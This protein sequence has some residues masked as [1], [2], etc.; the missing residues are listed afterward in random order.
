MHGVCVGLRFSDIVWWAWRSLRVNRV[1]TVLTM[2]GIIIG[3]AAIISLQ[4]VG[5][6]FQESIFNQL[7]QLNP[8]T[9]FLIPSVGQLSDVDVSRLMGIEGVKK[10]IPVITGSIQIY[11]T[12]GLR[13]FTLIGVAHEDLD[14]L[15]RG[16]ELEAGRYY[17]ERGEAIVGW[18]VAHPPDLSFNFVDVDTS[19]IGKTID[20]EGKEHTTTL[21]IVGAYEKLGAT[22]FFDPDRSVFVD[23]ETARSLL[24]YKGYGIIL[25]LVDNPEEIDG[26]LERI[27][28]MMGKR[29]EAFSASQVREVYDNISNQINNLLAGIAFISLIVAGVGITNVMLINVIE[30]TR[31]IGVLKA[32]GYTSR[33]V[34]GMFLSEALLIGVFGSF[35]GILA[36]IVLAYMAGS[37]LTFQFSGHMISTVVKTTPIFDIYYFIVAVFFGFLVSLVSGVYP[38]Y[39]AAKLDPVVALRY[40]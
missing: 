39:R 26:V 5:K 40:E 8:D 22:V 20:L 15:I 17:Y 27:D 4:A 13:T 29:V 24:G 31:E 6:G 28:L 18:N 35:I 7:F 10:V 38:A 23:K 2:L 30:R 9:I 25:V 21:R 33:Q 16:A 1:R 37:F 32:L 12:S 3:I 36:G 11:G 14:D 34:M 19:V